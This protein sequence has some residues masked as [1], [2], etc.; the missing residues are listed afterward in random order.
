MNTTYVQESRKLRDS[1]IETPFLKSLLTMVPRVVGSI[2][3]ETCVCECAADNQVKQ[4]SHFSNSF[5]QSTT[6]DHHHHHL[7]TFQSPASPVSLAAFRT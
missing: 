4:R 1:F 2:K 5:S 7:I 6:M 3:I